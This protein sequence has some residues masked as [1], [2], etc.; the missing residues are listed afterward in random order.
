M[1]TVTW[2]ISPAAWWEPTTRSAAA[3]DAA[4]HAPADL[5]EHHV[6]ARGGGAQLR[7]GGRRGVVGD[8]HGQVGGLVDE[9]AQRD[10]GPA[11]VGGG[12]HPSL[13]VD[14]AR[15]ADADSEH[16]VRGG[17]DDRADEVDDDCRVDAAAGVRVDGGGPLLE[18]VHL[19]GDVDERGAQAC[20]HGEVDRDGEQPGAVEVD[21]GG[22]LA[23]AALLRGADVAHPALGDELGDEVRHGHLRDPHLAGQLGAAGRPDAAQGLQDEGEVLP[24]AVGGQDRRRLADTARHRARHEQ[25]V[26]FTN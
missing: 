11:E 19:A 3:D 1:P 13:A 21:Q 25:L 18:V 24:A 14:D 9:V 8:E 22:A 20:G 26:N 6:L 2:P 23:R 12:A 7:L 5:D 17:G 16:R 4:A 15:G 10:V